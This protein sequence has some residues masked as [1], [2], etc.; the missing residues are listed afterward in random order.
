MNIK[1]IKLFY[2]FTDYYADG[3][4]YAECGYFFCKKI[5]AVDLHH[6]KSNYMINSCSNIKGFKN[7]RKKCRKRIAAIIEITISRQY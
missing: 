4:A 5:T 6:V 2:Y 1:L 7:Q 3:G